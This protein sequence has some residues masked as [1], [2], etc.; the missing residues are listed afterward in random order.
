MLAVYG[1]SLMA[2]DTQGALSAFEYEPQAV[3]LKA[4]VFTESPCHA[5]HA[6]PAPNPAGGMIPNRLTVSPPRAERR[7]YITLRTTTHPA[8]GPARGLFACTA[9]L[10]ISLNLSGFAVADPEDST[11]A[12]RPAQVSHTVALPAQ[13]Q[14]SKPLGLSL[15]TMDVSLPKPSGSRPSIAIV[16]SPAASPPPSGQSH[17]P[18]GGS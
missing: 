7:G 18:D 14:T 1:Q 13:A 9:A 2:V 16:T 3:G 12:S 6:T 15:V 5:V 4:A 8:T 10:A 17:T 11:P